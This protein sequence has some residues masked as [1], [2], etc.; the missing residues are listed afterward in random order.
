MRRLLL[1]VNQ[2]H[3]P[4]LQH[5]DQV[6]ECH[7]RGVGEAREHRLAIKHST[8]GDAIQS[9]RQL[10]IEPRFNRMRIAV[11]MQPGVGVDHRGGD[12]GTEPA[13][14]RRRASFDHVAEGAVDGDIEVSPANRPSQR[15]R[16]FEFVDEEHHARIG[17]PPENRLTFVVPGKDSMPV[18]VK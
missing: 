13:I 16:D 1:T 3:V 15:A 7:L 5:F 2:R 18:G 12:P 8:D 14:A 10:A 17:R 9:A 6:H 4:L 11:S